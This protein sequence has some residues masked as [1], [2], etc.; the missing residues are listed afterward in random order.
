MI[1]KPFLDAYA[2]HAALKGTG[3]VD[4]LKQLGIAEGFLVN[5]HGPCPACGGKDRFRFDNQN[6]GMFICGQ[7]GAG[8]GFKLVMLV[9]RVEFSEARKMVIDVGRLEGSE[10]RE[11]QR[12][13]APAPIRAPA[14]RS[15]PSSRVLNLTREACA[16]E[17]C[18]PAR[19]YLSRRGLWPLPVG[20]MLKAHPAVDYWDDGKRIG[21]FAAL[22]AAVRDCAGELVTAHV[23]Y[24]TLDG[25]KLVE[26][27]PRK[28]FTK[29][30]GR[31]GCHAPI[32][33]LDGDTLGIAEGIETAFSAA[34]LS[35][36]RT[37]AS[38]N[39]VLMAKFEPPE[40]VSHLVI[41]ADRDVPGL[42][43]AGRLM[44][45]LQERVRLE[46]RISR[47]KDFNADLLDGRKE[48]AA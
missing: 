20:A 21:R 40:N 1:E 9:Q 16:I 18:E 22:I 25:Q 15:M 48:L 14:E 44:Q 27:E 38:L 36:I 19:L 23:T 6:K 11:Q 34:K 47:L 3:W 42:E 37:W 24:L 8:D 10:F 32:M 2:I 31:E 43:A 29:M 30:L 17:D 13:S 41:F 33:E 35:G 39:A 7:C 28:I 12:A 4:V 46:L 45:R 26:Y 5:K